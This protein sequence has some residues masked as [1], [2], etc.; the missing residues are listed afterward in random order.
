MKLSKLVER[1]NY[2]LVSG[3]VDIDVKQFEYDSRKVGPGSVF[4]CIVGAV[5]DGHDYIN[6]VVK[7]GGS[8][9]RNDSPGPRQSSRAR[10]HVSRVL[11]LSRGSSEGNRRYG[12]EG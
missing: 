1:I 7:K 3:S 2:E 4:V 5:S 11:R 10:V 9:R 6:E 8:G 12:N